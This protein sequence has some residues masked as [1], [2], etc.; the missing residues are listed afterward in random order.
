MESTSVL[1]I[2]AGP[3]GLMLALE[4]ARL[5]VPFRLLEAQSL[6]KP[7]FQSRALNLHP[8]T[9]ELLARHDISQDLINAGS[10]VCNVRLF[11]GR[12]LCTEIGF[13]GRLM[14]DTAFPNAIISNQSLVE[15]ILLKK[16]EEY[17]GKIELG[18]KLERLEMKKFEQGVTAW[19][20]HLSSDEDQTKCQDGIEE[21]VQSRYIVGCDGAHSLVRNL[22]GIEFTGNSHPQEFILAD[23]YVDWEHKR[24]PHLFMDYGFTAFFPLND[25]NKYRIFCQRTKSLSN[26]TSL[27]V[28]LDDFGPEIAALVPGYTRIHSPSWISEFHLHSRIANTYRVQ[29]I[30]LA[31]DAAHIHTPVGG[32]GMNLGMQDS[33]N[34]AWK[35]ARVLHRT[36]P[37]SIL[38]SYD[39]ERRPVAS[40]IIRGTDRVFSVFSTTNPLK[41]WLRNFLFRWILPWLCIYNGLDKNMRNMS[42]LDIR[43]SKSPAVGTATKWKGV[44]RGGDRAPEGWI[45]NCQGQTVTLQKLWRAPVD[46]LVLFCSS[47]NPQIADDIEKDFR[48]WASPNSNVLKI[49]YSSLTDKVSRD[50]Y[51]DPDGKAHS[52]YQFSEPGYVLV[53]PDGHISY[54]GALTSLGELRIWMQKQA[55]S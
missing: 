54:I 18:S 48:E 11:A 1:I 43:Y 4:L 47:I 45:K 38:D 5:Q 39:A 24:C 9:L 29:S 21:V 3:T 25:D 40:A 6:S 36:A 23:A 10:K 37:A 14:N 55:N 34:L 53:R 27:N 41:V 2:G 16:L 50:D 42:Q 31:G 28:T 12:N 22:A 52:L 30:F 20:R 15:K 7:N 33:V 44:L 35:L 13:P 17:G 32:Q 8:R 51:I 46:H 26:T 19:V 49:Y